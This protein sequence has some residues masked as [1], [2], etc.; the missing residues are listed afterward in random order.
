M[1]W[2]D[3]AIVLAARPHGEANA[4]LSALTL[5]HGRH[6]GLVHGGA[7]KR[8]G[9]LL[10]PGNRLSLTWRAR[11]ADQLGH[12]RVEPMQLLASRLVH[13]PARL[14]ALTSACVLL[15]ESLPE[16]EAHPRLYAGLLRL[17]EDMVQNK[18]NGW[19]ETYVRFE[20]LL[21][22]D[23]GFGLDLGSCAL[24]GTADDLAYVSPRSGRAVGR[25]A[26]GAFAPRLLPLP[27]FLGGDGDGDKAAGVEE[28]AAGLRL[29]GHFL[30]KHVFAPADRPLPSSRE[31][32]ADR[33]SAPPVAPN[34]ADVDTG[35][36]PP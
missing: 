22:A 7:G 5:E 23:L 3:E 8:Q 19:P 17:L 21:L 16:R 30:A 28:L 29:T 1:E 20:L 35:T 4:V 36:E 12:F 9:P 32:L 15:E 33:L 26:A 6:A 24:T 2:Q 13:D 34:T 27:A 14:M 10:Q 25:A 11:L 31:R 18:N